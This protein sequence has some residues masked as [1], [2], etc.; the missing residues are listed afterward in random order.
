MTQRND[1]I[2]GRP[3]RLDPAT[4]YDPYPRYELL[5]SEDPVHWNEGIQAWI[6]T[7]HQDVLNALRDP[8]LSAERISALMRQTGGGAG[9]AALERTFLGMML[10][11][12]PPDHTRLRSLANKA[13]SLAVW[14]AQQTRSSSDGR[15]PLCRVLGW[16]SPKT[17]PWIRLST[18]KASIPRARAA[19]ATMASKRPGPLR[20]SIRCWRFAVV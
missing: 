10:F 17:S 1:P 20:R 14:S 7:R 2:A 19:S 9:A 4:V 5:R 18:P 8:R 6:L 16:D 13:L 12:D 3:G 11:S 15:R